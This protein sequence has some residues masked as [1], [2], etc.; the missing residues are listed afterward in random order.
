MPPG[1]SSQPGEEF[2]ER[3]R[4]DEIVVAARVQALNP[5]LPEMAPLTAPDETEQILTRAC[6]DCHSNKTKWPWYSRV[7]PV[8]WWVTDHVNEG[9]E[10]LNFSNWGLSN[11]EDQAEYA[12]EIIEEIEEGKM[13]MPSYVV[14]H[15]EAEL[16]ETDIATLRAWAAQFAGAGENEKKR[17][18]GSHDSDDD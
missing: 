9:R 7:A 2:F 10:H 18:H 12:E 13:P 4:L 14:G 1:K 5:I 17:G 8:S 3:E 15:P 11:A 6:Y 16:S